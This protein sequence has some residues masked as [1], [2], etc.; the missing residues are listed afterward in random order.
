M[1]ERTRPLNNQPA[2]PGPV[3]YWM[4]RDQRAADNWA[5]LYAQS[6][7]LRLGQPLLVVFCLQQ[8][9]LGAQPRHFAWMLAGL[10]ETA[11]DLTNLGIPFVI[12][13][14]D[15]VE[16]VPALAVQLKAGLIVND[17]S[18]L[19]V[20]RAWRAGIAAQAAAAGI[21]SVEVD[22][23]NIIPCWQASDKLEY[24]ARTIRPKIHRQLSA[25]LTEM[26]EL[27][28][29]PFALDEERLAVL[30][31][32][33]PVG[34][35]ARDFA[36]EKSAETDAGL[37][38]AGPTAARQRLAGFILEG[39]PSYG[40]RNDPNRPVTSR[41]SPYLHFGQISAQRVALAVKAAVLPQQHEVAAAEF[42]E[43][44]I[45]RRE[46]ADNFCFYNPQYDTIEGFPAWARQTLDRHRADPRAYR[47]SS[48]LL[49]AGQTADIL[50]NAAQQELVRQGTMPGY[51][52]MYWAKKLLEWC[53]SPELAMQIAIS[54]N[55]RYALDGR[56]PNGYTGIAWSIGG[57][58]DRPWG[59]RPVFGAI[60]F[61]SYDGCKRKFSIE[62]YVH[63]NQLS[64]DISQP[65]LPSGTR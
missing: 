14:G 46:L 52:R 1:L 49:E 22:A 44:L 55:D 64:F 56:D 35:A 5:L 19:R 34:L 3:I 62:D 61:M 18:P 37:P 27:S 59:E 8:Q 2:R 38:P 11:Q 6:E 58:H 54:F 65:N 4:N 40:D 53:A 31:T 9:F 50:W 24:A 15:P 57:V 60:R 51:L 16:R 17:F 43:E 25:Y 39:L 32:F 45:V 30:G 21:A 23:H 20:P 28:V 42:L 7:A 10:S 48:D 13:A 41:L 33:G 29:H 47:Y 36:L 26:P 12:A 63:K